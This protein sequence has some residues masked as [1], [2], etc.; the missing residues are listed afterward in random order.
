MSP[1]T[2]YVEKKTKYARPQPHTQ[3]PPAIKISQSTKQDWPLVTAKEIEA[4]EVAN[5]GKLYS[6]AVTKTSPTLS[7]V[8]AISSPPSLR[9]RKIPSRNLLSRNVF[10]LPWRT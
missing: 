8:A 7:A 10:P 9:V 1:Q 4:A 2:I 6:Q 5:T 3:T